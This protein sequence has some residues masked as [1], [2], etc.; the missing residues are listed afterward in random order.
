V[1]SFS[2]MRGHRPSLR[3]VVDGNAV[4][5]GSRHHRLRHFHRIQAG[6]FITYLAVDGSGYIRTID[7]EAKSAAALMSDTESKFDYVEHLLVGLRSVTY[8][9]KMRGK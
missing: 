3:P 5:G 4:Q 6:S 1:G 8:Y 9:G 7:P 2:N